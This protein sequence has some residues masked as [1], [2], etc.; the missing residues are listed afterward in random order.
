MGH[1]FESVAKVEAFD[2][3]PLVVLNAA[4]EEANHT[5]RAVSFPIRSGS[6][7]E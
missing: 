4:E 7:G 5:V 2:P 6:R 3:G 1:R